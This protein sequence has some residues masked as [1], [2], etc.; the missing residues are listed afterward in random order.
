MF[1]KLILKKIIPSQGLLIYHRILAYIAAWLYRYP[2][3]KMIVI[4][5]TGTSGKST[6]VNL[7]AKILEQAG[8]VCGLTTT[9]NFKIADQELINKSKMTMLGR[10]SLQRLLKK[11]VKAG[12][13]YA[14]IETTSQG[15]VQFRHLG[16]DYDVVVFTNLT[17]EHIESHGSLEAYRRAKEKLFQRLIKG[18]RKVIN[19][20]AVKKISV[21]NL[22][23]KNSKYFLNY[24]ADEKYGHTLKILNHSSGIRI[25]KA[26]KVELMDNGSEFVINNIRF[27]L[28]LLGAFNIDNALSAISVALS[29]R[30]DLGVCKI[31][32]EKVSTIAGRMEV[33][34]EKPMVVVD[35]AHTPDS[36]EKVYQTLKKTKSDLSKIICI[37]GAAGGGRDKWKRPIFGRIAEKYGDYIIITNE[38]PYD[39][40][41]KQII[42]EVVAGI[43]NRQALFNQKKLFKIID[44]RQAIKKAL[45]LAHTDDLIIITGKGSEQCIMGPK[46]KKIS[47][48]DKKVIQELLN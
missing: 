28:N 38:D 43:K 14:I 36:L 25:I 45:D 1:I 22:D 29:Q 7:I 33:V 40:D 4:G 27:K 8:F 31:A 10:F 2:S 12:C 11:M 20:K 30:L 9:F 19:G 34:A 3:R 5:V 35:Y 23:D 24:P 37:L 46:G 32:L 13:H 16:I 47:W 48:N 41:P 15:I 17:P 18:K 39:E 26:E 6:V 42:N 21:V 44:R